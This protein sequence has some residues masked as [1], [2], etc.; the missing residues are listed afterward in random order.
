MSGG[1]WNY[2]NDSLMNEIFGYIVDASEEAAARNPLE[3]R[4]ISE[5]VY[6]IF[7]L[8]HEFDWYKSGDTGPDAYRNAV[9]R[10]KQKWLGKPSEQFVLDHVNRA[11]ELTRKELLETLV[12]GSGGKGNTA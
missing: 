5:I 3:D 11:L 10:F 9:N 6:D 4:I 7:D 2:V 12:W 1:H 8:L